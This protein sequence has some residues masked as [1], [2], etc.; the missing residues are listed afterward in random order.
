MGLVLELNFKTYLNC[1]LLFA[2]LD[3]DTLDIYLG[4]SRKLNKLINVLTNFHP[5]NRYPWEDPG[6]TRPVDFLFLLRICK[7]D[8][9][10]FI[11]PNTSTFFRLSHFY[12]EF[13]VH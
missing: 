2:F 3:E 10:Y 9:E 1:F 11:I 13:C 7:M 12:Q 5:Q 8:I 6:I 4:E